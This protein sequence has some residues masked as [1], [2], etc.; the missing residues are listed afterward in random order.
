MM[1]HGFPAQKPDDHLGCFVHES[2][3]S[4]IVGGENTIGNAIENDIKA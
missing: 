2:D 3:L 1:A 4:I